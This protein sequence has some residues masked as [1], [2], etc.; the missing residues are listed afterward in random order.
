MIVYHRGGVAAT[1]NKSATTRG[2]MVWSDVA[3]W[4]AKQA[5]ELRHAQDC[6][7]TREQ[8]QDLIDA[9]QSGELD[10]PAAPAEES[11]ILAPLQ[12][13]LVDP[14]NY[15][16]CIGPFCNLAAAQEYRRNNRE[17]AAYAAICLRIPS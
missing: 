11:P 4:K 3:D 17:F 2:A 13:M 16:D 14:E 6:E 5:C 9:L 7:Y 15:A 12:A 8:L 1:Y 10:Q